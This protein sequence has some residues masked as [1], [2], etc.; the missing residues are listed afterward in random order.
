MYA[1]LAF[2]RGFSLDQDIGC[3]TFLVTVA[4]TCWTLG[5]DVGLARKREFCLLGVSK[6][7]FVKELLP[8][9]YYAFNR[10]CTIGTWIF[11]EGHE[12]KLAGDPKLS[13]YIILFNSACARGQA[14]VY[15]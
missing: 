10:I 7:Y 14:R 6:S 3:W 9:C 1:S 11:K 13:L 15:Y 2:D 4:S 5:Q 8:S 12:N